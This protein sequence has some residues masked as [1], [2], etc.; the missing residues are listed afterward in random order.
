MIREIPLVIGNAATVTG[1]TLATISHSDFNGWG[2]AVLGIAITAVAG[3]HKYKREKYLS[4]RER[5]LLCKACHDADASPP[6]CVVPPE[7]RPDACPCKGR[8]D[9]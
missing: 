6:S 1:A 7:Y 3:I 2:L 4:M 5:I 9:K 8:K